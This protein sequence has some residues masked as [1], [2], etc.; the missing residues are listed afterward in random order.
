LAVLRAGNKDMEMSFGTHEP[1]VSAIRSVGYNP[2]A[3]YPGGGYAINA[4]AANGLMAGYGASA[5]TGGYIAGQ[6]GP[7]YG[8][9]ITGT[10]IG[11]PGPPHIP[12]GG[13]AGL[14]KHVVR[15]HTRQ[16]I[17]NPTRKVKL[18]VKQMP[19]IRY[20]TPAN[21]AW[22]KQYNNPQCANCVARGTNGCNQCG[23]QY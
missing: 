22:I 9:P 5:G 12:L 2:A 4:N 23:G 6:T 1:P 21:R 17:P 19:G 7:A 14:Q 20:P 3:G 11:L 18:H 13:P 8:M 16:Y 10:P 15:N